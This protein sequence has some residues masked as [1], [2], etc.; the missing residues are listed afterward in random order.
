MS[1][2]RFFKFGAEEAWEGAF[3]PRSVYAVVDEVE[4][5][6]LGDEYAEITFGFVDQDQLDEAVEG[7]EALFWWSEVPR[8]AVGRL[9]INRKRDQAFGQ[10]IDD[11]EGGERVI[12]EM[13]LGDSVASTL[14][15]QHFSALTADPAPQSI[16]DYKRVRGRKAS[17]LAEKFNLKG[18]PDASE[19]EIRD[20]LE[21]AASEVELGVLFDVG[22]GSA[23]ALLDGSGS[24]KVYFDYG[25]GV[26]GNQRTYPRHNRPLCTLETELVIL[27]HWDW[28]HWANALRDRDRHVFGCRWLA[29]RDD[30][31]GPIHMALAAQLRG[32]KFWPKSLP[33]LKLGEISIHQCTGKSRND[34]GLA[35][36]WHPSDM[37]DGGVLFPGDC[38]Y[39]HLPKSLQEKSFHGLVASHHGAAGKT[40][41]KAPAPI[42]PEVCRWYVSAG[43]GNSYGHPTAAGYRQHT[44]AGWAS[45]RRRETI[46]RGTAFC[47]RL[48]GRWIGWPHGISGDKVFWSRHGGSRPPF[49]FVDP[50]E[51]DECVRIFL[52]DAWA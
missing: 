39:G 43:T 13:V 5:G 48:N 9:E 38:D 6:A 24:P 49:I 34:A 12:F 28:D 19:S 22:Q 29:P 35:V 51:P 3:E 8:L 16:M 2:N 4:P 37:R 17:E 32:L 30:T 14:Q 31:I 23:A 27:S 25:A 42:D 44:G 52:D 45:K 36:T 18:V 41:A 15:I 11:F 1:V 10:A 21:G 26:L 47:S 50:C 33:A 20:L 7:A 46:D 40:K